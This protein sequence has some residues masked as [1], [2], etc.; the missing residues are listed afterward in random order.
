MIMKTYYSLL[1]FFWCL[2][3]ITTETRGQKIANEIELEGVCRGTYNFPKSNRPPNPPIYYIL[4][5]TLTNNSD[6]ILEFL[7]FNCTP[8]GNILID[9]KK[10]RIYPNNCIQNT[11]ATIK[12]D[13][14]KKL[15]ISVILETDSKI[16]ND[17]IKIGWIFLNNQN[18]TDVDDFYKKL[19]Q[20]SQN[21]KNVIWSKK[22]SVGLY[23]KELEIL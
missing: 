16:I 12:L 8:S 23:N 20:A 7:T 5:I 6:K 21:N 11:I 17:S 22:L 14:E 1:I 10:Y 2:L 15:C 13:P 9:S 3:F 19:N 4:E 18:T